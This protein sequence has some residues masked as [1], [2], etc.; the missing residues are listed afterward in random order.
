MKKLRITAIFVVLTISSSADIFISFYSDFGIGDASDPTGYTPLLA[1]GEQALVQLIYAGENG[2]IDG[3]A[4]IGGAVYGDDVILSQILTPPAVTGDNLTEFGIW[5]QYN[6][7]YSG[8][9]SGNVYGRLFQD[10]SASASTCYFE[11]HMQ[12]ASNLSP[13]LDTPEGYDLGQGLGA[14]ASIGWCV[15]EPSTIGLFGIGGF[16]VWFCRRKSRR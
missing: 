9:L 6:V 7:T 13:G 15:P 5:T 2:V 3:P 16:G 12:V 14:T 8:A 1:A 4:G 11:G 10:A